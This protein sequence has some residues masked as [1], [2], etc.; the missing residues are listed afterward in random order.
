MSFSTSSLASPE[1]RRIVRVIARSLRP[2]ARE[3]SRTRLVFSPISFASL[4]PSRASTLTPPAA[5]S[6]SV[7]Y[8]TSASITVESILT[9]L[10]L[11]RFSLVAFTTSARVISDTVSAPIRRVSLH[12]VDSSGTRSVSEIRQNGADESSP[13]PPPP[14]SDTPTGTAA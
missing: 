7:G 9:A 6:E 2:I 12:T 4:R 13:T 14:T 11:N 5:R 8:F 1:R 3:R 10:G